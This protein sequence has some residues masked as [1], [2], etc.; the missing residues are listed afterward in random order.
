MR[1]AIL[2]WLREGCDLRK[3]VALYLRYGDNKT[4]K[5]VLISNPES[6]KFRLKSILCSM[7]GTSPANLSTI[8]VKAEQD[9]FR[10][11][12]PFL[13]KKEIPVEI[14]ILAT[15]KMT[16]Y[17]DVVRL[18]DKL[19]ICHTN[20]DCL[21]T[22]SDLVNAFKD[23]QA[24]KVELD[25]Y[26]D[27]GKVLGRHPIFN[28]NRRVEEIRRMSVRDLVKREKQLRDNIWRIKS[29]MSKNDKPHLDYE[30]KQRLLERENELSLVLKMLDE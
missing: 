26:R 3:G 30:R 13:A 28:Q 16:T 11:M 9:N 27:F 5:K 6:S 20:Q 19:F 1:E 29:E 24:I 21:S 10:K 2:T 7:A 23:D 22:A 14:K 17:W 12:Y 25:H 15:D 4:F 8:A 18:H